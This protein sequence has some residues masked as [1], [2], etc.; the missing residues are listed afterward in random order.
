MT[1]TEI[2]EAES[3]IFRCSFCGKS[4]KDVKKLIAGPGE[5]FI[6]DECVG[7][8]AEII[9]DNPTELK[10]SE[11]QLAAAWSAMLRNRAKAAQTAEAEL[12]KLVRRARTKGLE[13]STIADA[14]GLAPEEVEARF[15]PGN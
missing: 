7:L 11:A 10:P 15:G 14:L 13:W 6:C 9:T 8:C 1:D 3:A 4:Q 2:P 5:I 12:E